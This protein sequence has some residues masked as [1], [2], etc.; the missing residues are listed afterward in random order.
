MNLFSKFILL[1][2]SRLSLLTLF[3]IFF[4][5]VTVN[6]QKRDN[7]SEAEDSLIREIQE[8]D[9]RMSF[10]VKVIDRRLLALTDPNAGKSK[11]VQKDLELW[12]ELRNG[13]PAE[14]LFDIQRTLEEAISKI[15]DA[16]ARDQKNPL[17]GKAVGIISGGCNRFVPQLKTLQFSEEKERAFIANS[18]DYCEQIIEASGKMPKEALQETKKKK[19]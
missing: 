17:F 7:L 9:G 16:S 10:F 5:L 13:T 4:S 11:Q 12:G 18:I 2:F 6:A 1:L 14:L 19:N 15:D 8:I 3:I